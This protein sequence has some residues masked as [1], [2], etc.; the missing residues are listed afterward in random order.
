MEDISYTPARGK[1]IGS[2]LFVHGLWNSSNLWGSW[3]DYFASYGYESW[4]VNLRMTIDNPSIGIYVD[5]VTKTVEYIKNNFGV[6]P[7]LIGHSMGGLISQIVAS[8]I[9]VSAMVLIAS[10]GP[11]GIFSFSWRFILNFWRYLPKLYLKL[12]IKSLPKTLSDQELSVDIIR[13]LS[14]KLGEVLEQD[15]AAKWGWYHD[16]KSVEPPKINTV[17]REVLLGRFAI[18]RINCPVFIIAGQQDKVVSFRAQRSL[19]KRYNSRYFV[20]PYGH[21]ELINHVS[22]AVPKRILALIQNL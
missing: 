17:I 11:F 8:K 3:S 5:Q 6:N 4:A 22:Y 20:Y 18:S 1:T 7:I 12:V 16:L 13:H 2:I 14:P 21:M 19:A 10:P 9:D 15:L